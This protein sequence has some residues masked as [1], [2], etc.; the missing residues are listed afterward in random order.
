MT[1]LTLTT[2]PFRIT[3]PS[4]APVFQVIKGQAAFTLSAIALNAPPVQSGINPIEGSI[5]IRFRNGSNDNIP[6]HRIV[7]ADEVIWSFWEPIGTTTRAIKALAP[8]GST[9]YLKVLTDPP[10]GA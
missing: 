8:D 4:G 6:N 2:G 10:A 9:W 7:V 5:S 1:K 3:T